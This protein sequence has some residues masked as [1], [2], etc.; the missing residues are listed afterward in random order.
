MSALEPERPSEASRSLA[1]G[2]GATEE[3]VAA[4]YDELRRLARAEL[5]RER[6]SPT[7]QPTALVHEAFVRLVGDA[8]ARWQCRRHF[9]GAAALAMRRVLVERAR[10]R[11]SQK[12]GDGIARAEADLEA[13]SADLERSDEDVLE[14]ESALER[15]ARLDRRKSDVVHLRYFLGLSV[16]ETAESLEISPTT[17]KA[18]WTF[19]R[20]WLRREIRGRAPGARQEGAS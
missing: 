18:D 9:V 5:S 3:L 16:E 10:A 6:G 14:L 19:A 13:L 20:A 7:L 17:V 8:G 2:D 1:A 12:R 11:Q 4:L 15:L